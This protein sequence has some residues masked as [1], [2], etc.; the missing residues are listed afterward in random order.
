MSQCE[1]HWTAT[2][3]DP[4]LADLTGS[5]P[6]MILGCAELTGLRGYKSHFGKRNRILYIARYYKS[7]ERTVPVWISCLNMFEAIS[8]FFM[9]R[10]SAFGI[11]CRFSKGYHCKHRS[12]TAAERNISLFSPGQV[13][14]SWADGAA[15]SR[16]PGHLT[17]PSQLGLLGWLWMAGYSQ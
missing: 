10:T 2:N 14:R 12:K 16:G 13:T 4:I 6:G 17:S 15:N 7:F 11:I 9:L 5:Q 3:F 1:F 8:Q